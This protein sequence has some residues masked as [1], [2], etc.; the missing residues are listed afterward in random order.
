MKRLTNKK[1]YEEIKHNAEALR[2]A[3][4]EP[5]ISD[6]RYMKLAEY[7]DIEEMNNKIKYEKP[8]LYLCDA[9]KRPQCR[10]TACY[11]N[12]GCCKLTQY[13]EYAKTDENGKPIE[14]KEGE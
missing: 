13:K 5:T 11:V 4:F 1:T 8:K 6:Q 12:G 7:E 10:A 14:Y 3:G 9:T 2:A